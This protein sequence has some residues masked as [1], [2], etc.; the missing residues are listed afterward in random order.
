[1]REVLSAACALVVLS[2]ATALTACGDPFGGQPPLLRED[3]VTLASATG[4]SSLPT[5]IDIVTNNAPAFPEKPAE[6][7]D[8]DL[9]VRTSGSSFVLHPNPGVSP[10]RGAGLLR[11]TRDFT[12]PGSAPRDNQQYTRTDVAIQPGEVYYVQSRQRNNSC[13]TLAKFG[14]L[15]VLSVRAD[16]GVVHLVVTSNQNCDD[17]RLEP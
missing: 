12:D 6:A 17:E 14:V 5:A 8:W 16:S 11:T 10:Y 1:M 2:A 3:S 9:Q 4:P 15:K 7:G 13:G